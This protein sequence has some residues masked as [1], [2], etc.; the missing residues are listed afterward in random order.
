M[1]QTCWTLPQAELNHLTPIRARDLVIECFYY[2][3]HETFARTRQK[4]G[5]ARVDDAALRA[6]ITAAV[7]IAFRESGGDP[8]HPTAATLAAAVAVLG[9]KA[10]S[11]GTPPDIIQHHGMQIQ[12]ML[13][14]LAHA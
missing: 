13:E 10:A 7:R 1:T 4:L 6:D 9:R 12:G 8:D 2:A 3:Q 14:R 5:A 11:W